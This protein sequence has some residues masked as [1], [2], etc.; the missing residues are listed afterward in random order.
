MEEEITELKRTHE[1]EKTKSCEKEKA[2]CEEM[3][4][5]EEYAQKLES[6]SERLQASNKDLKQAKDELGREAEFWTKKTEESHGQFSEL[7]KQVQLLEGR[8]SDR[9]LGKACVSWQ[10][11]KELIADTA[12]AEDRD[13]WRIKYYLRKSLFDSKYGK[14][15]SKAKAH[16]E[17]EVHSRKQMKKLLAIKDHEVSKIKRQLDAAV[18]DLHQSKIKR[19]AI[20]AAQCFSIKAEINKAV[21]E[22][23]AEYVDREGK[24]TK[25]FELV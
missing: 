6:D 3:K 22:Q 23:L 18:Q 21:N 25:L 24:A 1:I 4:E 20:K 16:R 7:A 14:L 15:L 19:L 2:L 9:E 17:T 5:W 12:I 11:I 13:A 8:H 10:K